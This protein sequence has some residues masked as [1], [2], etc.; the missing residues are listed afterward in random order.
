MYVLRFGEIVEQ[1][2]SRQLNR[3]QGELSSKLQAEFKAEEGN[4][5]AVLEEEIK[6]VKLLMNEKVQEVI[7]N[8]TFFRSVG[9]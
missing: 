5:I 6:L 3:A 7:K 9:L 8:K 4:I 2:S 1:I